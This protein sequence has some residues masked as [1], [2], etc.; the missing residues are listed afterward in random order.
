[1]MVVPALYTL[2]LRLMLSWRPSGG[3]RRVVHLRYGEARNDD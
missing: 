1:M 3:G 2:H